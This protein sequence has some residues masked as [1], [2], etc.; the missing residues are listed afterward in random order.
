MQVTDKIDGFEAG[1]DDYVTKPAHLAEVL[2]RVKAL[3]R[4]TA[5]R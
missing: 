4:R 3:L 2:A 1:A 5:G